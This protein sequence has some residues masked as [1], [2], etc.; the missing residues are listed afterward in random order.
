MFKNKEKQV[1]DRTILNISRLEDYSISEQKYP[2]S[3]KNIKNIYLR[4]NKGKKIIK[5]I[6]QTVLYSVMQISSLDLLLKNKQ[7][8]IEN[9]TKNIKELL[10]HITK[11]SQVTLNSSEKTSIAYGELI[12]NIDKVSKNSN[13]LLKDTINSQGQ[14]MEI[15]AFSEEVKESSE[16]LDKDMKELNKVIDNVERVVNSIYAISEQTNLLALNASIEA[17]R[18]GESG[19]GF[20]VVAEQIRKLADETK[21]LTSDMGNFVANIRS[22]SHKSND[23]VNK[24]VSSLEN[25]N[26]RLETMMTISENNKETIGSVANEIEIVAVTSEKISNSMNEILESMK[27]L[28]SSVDNING[29]VEDLLE[30]SHSLSNT[31]EP[32]EKIEK[33]LH[34]AVESVGE[35]VS[36]PYYTIDNT[37]FVNTIENAIKAHKIWLDN[38]KKIVLDE[39]RDVVIQLDDHKCAFGHFYYSI[40]PKNREILSIW[41]NIGEK[42]FRFHNIGK[43]A[44][45]AVKNEDKQ[46]INLLLKEA[47]NLSKILIGDFDKIVSITKKLEK[48]KRSVFIE[49]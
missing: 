16:T 3:T 7:E 46:K 24:T 9:I 18:A 26:S 21:L 1:L 33:E 40:S 23:S 22:A 6:T 28:D 47:E 30:V 11:V 29:D 42:H 8:K 32:V 34:K 35:I 31:I 19:K 38:L 36:D 49:D 39:R 10:S 44:I 41:S 4:I 2:E 13:K 14:L 27:D 12:E 5:N 15:K 43:D 48:E 45:K 20:S 25:I 17:A 37:V